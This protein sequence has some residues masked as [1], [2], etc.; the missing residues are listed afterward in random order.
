MNT[1]GF[2]CYLIIDFMVLGL[3]IMTSLCVILKIL[4]PKLDM[5][6]THV[7]AKLL[8]HGA[9]TYIEVAFSIED[10]CCFLMHF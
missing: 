10:E 7:I 5:C 3:Q 9:Y 6:I 1:I 4:I 8:V 2:L